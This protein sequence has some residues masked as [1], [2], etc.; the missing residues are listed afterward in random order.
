MI[1]ILI[2][3]LVSGTADSAAAAAVGAGALMLLLLPRYQ[4]RAPIGLLA[5]G[6]LLPAAA[7]AKTRKIRVI[8]RQLQQHLTVGFVWRGGKFWNRVVTWGEG[9]VDIEKRA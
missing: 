7:A 2:L 9:R 1:F 3:L 8:L 6:L 4:I 5:R